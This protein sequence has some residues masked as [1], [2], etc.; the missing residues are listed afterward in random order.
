LQI[1]EST[2]RTHLNEVYAKTG[3]TRQAQLVLALSALQA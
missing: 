2:V 1:A 3:T